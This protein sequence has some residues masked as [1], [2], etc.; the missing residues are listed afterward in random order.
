MRP[1]IS[2]LALANE[3][4]GGGTVVVLSDKMSMEELMRVV[5]FADGVDL[6]GTETV[7]R[8]GSPLQAAQ[9]ARVW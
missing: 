4:E 1:L 9:I 5:E 2:Q 6:R 3:S 8:H 7:V